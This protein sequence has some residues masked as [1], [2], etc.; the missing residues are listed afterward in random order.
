MN[1]FLNEQPQNAGASRRWVNNW[2]DQDKTV[3]TLPRTLADC[4]GARHN[5]S[6]RVIYGRSAMPGTTRRQAGLVL[7][8]GHW[9]PDGNG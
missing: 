9:V 3:G 2:V 7:E 8:H 4:L 5:H 1:R 6:G